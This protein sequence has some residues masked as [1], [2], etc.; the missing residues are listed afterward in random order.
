M[1][2]IFQS[3]FFLNLFMQVYSLFY[4]EGE[5]IHVCPYTVGEFVLKSIYVCAPS[6]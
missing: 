3:A 2:L 5:N 1:Y 6:N 4:I